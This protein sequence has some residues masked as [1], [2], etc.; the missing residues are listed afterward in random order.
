MT[1]IKGY[2]QTEN[3]KKKIGDANREKIFVYKEPKKCLICNNNIGLKYR[4]SINNWNKRQFCSNHCKIICQN[5]DRVFSEETRKKMRESKIKYSEK[6]GNPFK[7][8]GMYEKNILDN[9]EKYFNYTILRQHKVAGYF[10]DGYCPALNLN[11]EIDE[12]YHKRKLIKEKDFRR[13]NYI[14]EKLGLNIVR[15]SIE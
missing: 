9:L 5:K 8:I 2:K 1:F 10:L 7:T 15:I 3:H 14:K 4:I 12:K 13:D 11:I 6:T